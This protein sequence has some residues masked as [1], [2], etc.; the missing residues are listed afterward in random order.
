MPLPHLHLVGVPGTPREIL[1]VLWGAAHAYQQ[2]SDPH[3]TIRPSSGSRAILDVFSLATETTDESLQVSELGEHHVRETRQ[4]S[5]DISGTSVGGPTKRRK[6]L[7]ETARGPADLRE[8]MDSGK[9]LRIFGQ[10]DLT[11]ARVR[12]GLKCWVLPCDINVISHFPPPELATLR[13]SSVFRVGRTSRIYLA[14][15]TKACRL[16]DSDATSRFIEKATAVAN[17]FVYI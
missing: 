10:S 16:N 17:G 5:L 14:H 9:S 7:S 3:T 8:F 15:L 4:L 1:R 2:Q 6:K 13:W 12:S 11:S